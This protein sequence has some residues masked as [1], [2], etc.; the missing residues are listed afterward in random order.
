M[1]IRG[2][3]NSNAPGEP[4]ALL[5]VKQIV[6]EAR[7]KGLI[8]GYMVDIVSI[9]KNTP[10]IVLEM[11]N[12]MESSLS[13]ILAKD[14][15]KEIWRIKINAKH[16]IKR[17]R[18]TLAHEYAHYMLHRDS[19]GTFVDEVIY[20][21]K[22]SDSAIEYNADKFA[23]E[24]LMPEDDFRRAVDSGHKSVQELSDLFNVSSIA[25]EIRAKSLNFKTRSNEG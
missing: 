21:R 23:A 17:Q 7:K 3:R 19:K 10:D 15:E 16:H 2:R 12:N 20:F 9:V 6:E 8:D 25:V 14:K 13:G 11:D 22:A 5:D 4:S 18:F 24:L 1:G